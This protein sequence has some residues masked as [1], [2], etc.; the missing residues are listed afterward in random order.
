M[1]IIYS[2]MPQILIEH[3]LCTSP[4]LGVEDIAVNKR[5]KNPCPCRD[6]IP[7]KYKV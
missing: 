7:V 4:V 5:D 2:F 1:M 6:T 3:L